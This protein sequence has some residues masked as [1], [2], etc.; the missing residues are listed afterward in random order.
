MY[1]LCIHPLKTYTYGGGMHI[2]I[3]QVYAYVSSDFRRCRRSAQKIQKT[4]NS[5]P[6]D[7]QIKKDAKKIALENRRVYKHL[8]Y[9]IHQYTIAYECNLSCANQNQNT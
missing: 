4:D 8:A 3:F 5:T 7:P 6:R 2:I 1:I 9:A